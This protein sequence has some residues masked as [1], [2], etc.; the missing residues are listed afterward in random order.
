MT[1]FGAIA[2]KEIILFNP[3]NI[4]LKD[5]DYIITKLNEDPDKT[6]ILE[7]K[8]YNNTYIPNRNGYFI[9]DMKFNKIINTIEGMFKDCIYLPKIDLSGIQSYNIARINSSFSN[10]TYLEDIIFDKFN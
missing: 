3:S 5:N 8:I 7:E 1:I 6:I 9:F 2:N 4:G 10:C